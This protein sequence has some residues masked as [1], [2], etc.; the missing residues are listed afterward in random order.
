[1]PPDRR[2][3]AGLLRCTT[4]GNEPAAPDVIAMDERQHAEQGARRTGDRNRGQRD[5]A[6]DG[7]A[8]AL[9]RQDNS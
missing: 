2:G 4:S 1:M 5:R 6:T 9:D 3:L 7:A 8:A